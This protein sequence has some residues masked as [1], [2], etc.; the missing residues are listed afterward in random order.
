M[1]EEAPG[2][3]LSAGHAAGAAAERAGVRIEGVE[4]MGAVREVAD[5]FALVWGRNAEG[6]PI[7]SEMLRSLAH[8]GGLVSR[9]VTS[10]G[11][12]AG[13]AVL[14]RAEPAASYSFIAGVRPGTSDRGIG[15][16]LKQHQRAWA[17]EHGIATMRWTFDPLV[18][19]NARFNLTKLGARARHYEAGFY[20]LMA[21]EINGSD[22]ADRLVAT[23]ELD[24]VSA[25]LAAR[26]GEA[27]PG[28]PGPETLLDPGPDGEPAYAAASGLRW[29]RVPTDIVA[30]RKVAPAEA[31]AWREFARI[32]LHEA[33]ENGFVA[34]GAS[35]TGWY[36]LEKESQ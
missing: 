1:G 8:A 35:R 34:V 9:A 2:D 20:G 25:A 26:G 10:S 36:R 16:A 5:L 3:L 31:S 21:D 19:R 7:P 28:D 23:W 15:F 33:I 30:L 27:D 24:S 6:V 12:V 13:A 11:V 17:L 29:C 4:E 18:G 14:G 32:R 22:I